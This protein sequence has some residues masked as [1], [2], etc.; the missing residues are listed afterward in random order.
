VVV[1]PGISLVVRLQNAAESFEMLT[2]TLALPVGT[3]TIRHR[4]RCLSGE[5]PVV[6]DIAPQPSGAGFTQTRC[7]HRHRYGFGAKVI[8]LERGLE[9]LPL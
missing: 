1:Q 2:R 7:Q 4:R 3:V 8:N 9:A 6:A 5:W